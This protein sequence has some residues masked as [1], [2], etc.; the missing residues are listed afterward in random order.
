MCAFR[1]YNSVCAECGPTGQEYTSAAL[2]TLVPWPASLDPQKLVCGASLK[3]T[4]ETFSAIGFGM[5]GMVQD[6]EGSGADCHNTRFKTAADKIHL[7]SKAVKQLIISGKYSAAQLHAKLS[8]YAWD[9]WAHTMATPPVHAADGPCAACEAF[10]PAEYKL[11]MPT[12]NKGGRPAKAKRGGVCSR[13]SV[14]TQYL[15]CTAHDVRAD[16]SH[17]LLCMNIFSAFQNSCSKLPFGPPCA[18]RTTASAGS[19]STTPHS[20]TNDTSSSTGPSTSASRATP[21]GAAL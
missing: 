21:N 19:S 11:L 2:P 8:W 13:L 9:Q 7:R 10:C 16:M 12:I 1:A 3:R 14:C 17:V 20:N 18:G 15:R 5:D 4:V 6:V